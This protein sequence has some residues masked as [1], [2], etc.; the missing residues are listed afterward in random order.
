MATA[1][2]GHAGDGERP[3]GSR[4]AAESS[5]ADAASARGA[6]AQEAD[7]NLEEMASKLVGGGLHVVL[8]VVRPGGWGQCGRIGRR[9]SP[10][11]HSR[12]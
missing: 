11:E 10:N 1:E 6:N 2:S 4:D 7:M 3:E 12:R 8:A 5:R 9:L